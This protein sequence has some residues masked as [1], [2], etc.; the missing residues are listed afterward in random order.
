MTIG[1]RRKRGTTWATLTRP[2]PCAA[3]IL[4]AWNEAAPIHARHNQERLIER[5]RRPG[6]SCLDEIETHRLTQLGVRGK[7]VAQ[8]CCNNG[9]ELLSVKNLGAARCVGFDGASAFIEQA[10]ELA[11]VAGLDVAFVCGDV[12]DIDPAYAQSFDLATI[13]IGVLGWMPELTRFFAVAAS[14]LKPGGALFLYE[15]HPIMDMF[16]PGAADAPVKFE[17]SYFSK[18]P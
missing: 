16:E 4:R 9:Q 7:D 6:Y 2:A 11:Q 18:E 3:P 12:Y 13:T 8:I 1:A 17:L 14:L 5:F 15:Q 10:R